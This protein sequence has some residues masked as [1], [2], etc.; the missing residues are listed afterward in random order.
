MVLYILLLAIHTFCK[1]R[2]KLDALDAFMLKIEGDGLSLTMFSQILEL[3]IR[4][5]TLL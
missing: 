5:V 1:V 2:V 4:T 3:V